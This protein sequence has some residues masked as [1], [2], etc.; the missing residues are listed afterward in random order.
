MHQVSVLISLPR[1]VVMQPP[2]FASVRACLVLTVF[3][4]ITVPR[5]N[6]RYIFK[7]DS[8]LSFGKIYSNIRFKA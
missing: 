6:R 7:R 4:Q 5:K 8:E 3:L 2:P 1:F